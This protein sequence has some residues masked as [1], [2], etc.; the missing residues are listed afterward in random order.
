M[1]LEAVVK[2]FAGNLVVKGVSFSVPRGELVAITGRSGAGKSTLLRLMQGVEQPDSGSVNL[3]GRSLGELTPRALRQLIRDQIGVG[4]QAPMLDGNFTLADNIRGLSNATGHRSS[5]QRLGQLAR[6]FELDNR[7]FQD[8]STCSG[9]EQMRA[10]LM[11]ALFKRPSVVLLDEPT[12]ALD[13]ISS[14]RAFA[15]LRQVVRQEGTTVVAVTHDADVARKYVDR[16]FVIDS[17]Q[18]VATEIYGRRG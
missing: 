5:N 8:A 3:L 15:G 12:G 7:L 1:V 17:G 10:A 9:G 6:A 16:E 14:E 13:T 2:S 18:V 11:R 4:F